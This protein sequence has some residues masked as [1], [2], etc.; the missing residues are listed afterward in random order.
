[1]VTGSVYWEATISVSIALNKSLHGNLDLISVISLTIFFCT[2]KTLAIFRVTL[3]YNSIF[4]YWM[5]VSTVGHC[6]CVCITEMMRMSSCITGGSIELWY[7][8]FY[9]GVPLHIFSVPKPRNFI[10][11]TSLISLSWSRIWYQSSWR[12]FKLNFIAFLLYIF[13]DNPITVDHI[14]HYRCRCNLQVIEVI[15]SHW[16]TCII[17]KQRRFR[18]AVYPMRKIINVQHE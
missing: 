9:I 18:I 8:L 16:Y 17:R 10:F 5:A 12:C 2:W 3:E 11:F 6:K 7:Y 1:M 14:I 15:S 4:H 13:G